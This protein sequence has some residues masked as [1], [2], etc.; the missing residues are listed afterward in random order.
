M[1]QVSILVTLL[2]LGVCLLS[3]N[4]LLSE[5][6]QVRQLDTVKSPGK[7]G[8]ILV[9]HNQSTVADGIVSIVHFPDTSSIEIT[10]NHKARCTHASLVGRL[11]GRT[12]L[13]VS[14]E[15]PRSKNVLS[16]IGGL[17]Q[18]SVK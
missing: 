5:D 2:V 7:A 9:V 8:E 17:R 18:Q 12:L 16:V 3:I 1:K 4:I 10:F 14:L 15:H 11:S 6:S 13:A